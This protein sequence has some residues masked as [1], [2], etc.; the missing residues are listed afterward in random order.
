MDGGRAREGQGGERKGKTEGWDRRNTEPELCRSR[1]QAVHICLARV[2]AAV[3]G[4]DNHVDFM[5]I[6]I[7]VAEERA[8]LGVESASVDVSN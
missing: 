8:V 4:R 7:E 2:V 3:D 1:R 5:C 6:W